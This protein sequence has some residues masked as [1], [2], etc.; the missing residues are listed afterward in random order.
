[1]QTGIRL[2]DFETGDERWLAYPV[3][4]DEQESVASLDALPGFS[5]T[6]DSKTIIASYGG[7]IWR[8]PVDGTEQT[9]IP[10]H[11]QS[12]IELGA[13]LAFNYRVSDS[14]EFIVRQIRD[15]VPSPDGKQLAFVSMDKVYLM[16]YP[17]GTP[18]RVSSLEGSESQPAWSG[19]GRWIAY[20]SWTKDGGQIYKVASTG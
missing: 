1:M 9:A 5:F 18:R 16:D 8:V 10:F 13:K 6:P 19:D 20:V 14:V 4:R 15:G 17:A 2:R 12:Q 7:K 3:Q 11:V